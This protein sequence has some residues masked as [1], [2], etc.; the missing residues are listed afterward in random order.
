MR[1]PGLRLRQVFEHATHFKVQKPGGQAITIAKKGLSPSTVGRLRRFAQG[2]EV[3]GYDDGGEVT[4]PSAEAV[5]DAAQE[6]LNAP[7]ATQGDVELPAVSASAPGIVA[8]QQAAAASAVNGRRKVVSGTES[9][10]PPA[11]PAATV[12]INN[13]PA[14]AQ[15]AP[16]KMEAAPKVEAKIEEPKPAEPVTTEETPSPVA[17]DVGLTADE[18]EFLF[19]TGVGASTMAPESV[20]RAEVA[21]LG[22]RPKVQIDAYLEGKQQGMNPQQAAEY[23]I[24]QMQQAK[25]Q[26]IATVE[27]KAPIVEPQ[28]ATAPATAPASSPVPVIAPAPAST[29]A[30]TPPAPTPPAATV[31]EPITQLAASAP[32]V[33]SPTAPISTRPLEP[34]MTDQQIAAVVERLPESVREPVRMV[35]TSQRDERLRQ[36]HHENQQLQQISDDAARLKVAET[37]AKT[38]VETVRQKMKDVVAQLAEDRASGKRDSEIG[39]KI[40]NILAL[41]VSGFFAGYTNTPNYALQAFGRALD[42]DVE[43]RKRRSDALLTELKA[44]TGSEETAVQAY[45]A[46]AQQSVAIEARRAEALATSDKARAAYAGVAGKFALEAQRTAADVELKTAQTAYTNANITG[47][48]TAEE[49]LAIELSKQQDCER[50]RQLEERRL[51]EQ[52]AARRL[53]EQERRDAVKD[54][55]E[56][57]KSD[58]T[59]YVADVPLL[60]GTPTQQRK[61]E[62][63]ILGQNDFLSGAHRVL[64]VMEENPVSIYAPKTPARQQVE[65]A[66]AQLLERYPKSER[67]DRPLNFTASKVVKVGLPKVGAAG[68]LDKVFGDPVQVMRELIKDVEGTREAAITT[69]GARTPEAARQAVK[70]LKRRESSVWGESI[71][72]EPGVK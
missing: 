56:K 69:Y 49:K 13:P 25:T 44:L 54:K 62:T 47:V 7:A 20:R 29:K 18:R 66:L 46:I 72:F 65:I 38:A 43:Q 68:I 11:A 24:K 33:S 50:M 1:T 70:E 21:Y 59:F 64:Q 67:F 57:W 9:A 36:I 16:R 35:L 4:E 53:R 2:G 41:A 39:S 8:A 32:S 31:A 58:R 45:K 12:I 61:A 40:V 63:E 27:P 14:S 42:R 22:S 51:A 60:A 17:E 37:E 10:V 28:P 71:D 30:V 6:S 5:A 52:A 26:P 15:P 34:A 23:S 19:Q 48:L 55:D 3:R